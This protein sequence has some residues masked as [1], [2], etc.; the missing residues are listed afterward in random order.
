MKKDNAD[1]CR[2][3]LGYLVISSSFVKGGVYNKSVCHEVFE[4]YKIKVMETNLTN[5][6]TN[7]KINITNTISFSSAGVKV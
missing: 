7:M 1:Y 4:W 2:F 3:I 6:I 5:I